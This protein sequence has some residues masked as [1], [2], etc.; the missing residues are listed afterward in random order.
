MSSAR[1]VS[2]AAF[3]AAVF[4]SWGAEAAAPVVD[5]TALPEVPVLQ[6]VS[7][8]TPVPPLALRPPVL[9]A[10]DPELAAV[11]RQLD[12]AIMERSEQSLGGPIALM[13]GGG[14]AIVVS[15]YALMFNAMNES[16]CSDAYYGDDCWNHDKVR[17][18]S[19]VGLAAGGGMLLG[20]GLWLGDRV[21]TRRELGNEINSLKRQRENLL[22]QPHPVP[23]PTQDEFGAASPRLMGAS[24]F[25]GVKLTL[26]F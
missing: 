21:S 8:A 16:T 3:G 15:L 1:F 6:N 20:G 12:E 18:Y 13:I 14:A 2:L 9:G 22:R 17:A 11:D 19:Y 26:E 23:Q 5:G 7:L 25:R 24:G 4:T 10:L